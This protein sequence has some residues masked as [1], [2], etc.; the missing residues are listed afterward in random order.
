MIDTSSFVYAG[1]ASLLFFSIVYVFA[2]LKDRYDLIDVAWGL[3]FIVI[4]FNSLSL[5]DLQINSIQFLTFI[6]V[7]VWA[8]RLSVHIYDR[9]Q[10]SRREDKR[11][12]AL[13]MR[14]RVLLGGVALN[15][16]I[17]VFVL[18]ALLAFIVSLPVITM[19]ASDTVLIGGIAI[20]GTVVWIVGF[21]FEAIGDYQ[22]RKFMQYPKNKGRLM[23]K[24]LWRYTRHP[25]YFGEIIQWWGI[26]II[27][28]SVAGIWWLSIV[29]P[30]TITILLLFVSGVPLTEKYFAKKPGWEIYRVRTSKLLPFPPKKV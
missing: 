27:S 19:N 20:V 8:A 30:L 29:G 12:A 4:A 2:K 1:F 7:C 22:L 24:G 10:R 17:K 28:L 9:W 6:L 11:Y 14:Y 5:F 21:Y 26:F 16:Y 3:A 13:R 25:N 23:T 18:Q 15:M